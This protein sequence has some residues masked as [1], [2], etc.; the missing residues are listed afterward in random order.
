[1]LNLLQ[2]RSK[3]LQRKY[4]ISA[5]TVNLNNENE[6]KKK[7]CCQKKMKMSFVDFKHK[8]LNNHNSTLMLELHTVLKFIEE[9]N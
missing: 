3:A 9:V 7:K 4:E 8:G 2:H 1:M 5:F 6:F